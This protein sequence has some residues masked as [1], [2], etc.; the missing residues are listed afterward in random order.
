MKDEK[1]LSKEE[2]KNEELTDEQANDAAGGVGKG[3]Q[4]TCEGECGRTY[5]CS[6]I[7]VNGKKFCAHCYGKYKEQMGWGRTGRL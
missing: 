3:F 7:V 6:P 5:K 4:F 2:I 1:K